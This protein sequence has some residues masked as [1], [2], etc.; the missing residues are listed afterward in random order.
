[1]LT[2]SS[3]THLKTSAIVLASTLAFV[4]TPACL[5]TE[6]ED[7]DGGGGAG[8]SGAEA[9]SG[10]D[11]SG[12]GG[13][14]S[15]G[16]GTGGGVTGSGG[17]G[18]TMVTQKT[19]GNPCSS[20]L[21]VNSYA[22]H[23]VSDTEVWLGCG[24]ATGGVYRSTDGGA[25]WQGY[26]FEAGGSE[27]FWDIET[28]S[29]GDVLL[30]G[31][32]NPSG[33]D[34][35]LLIRYLAAEDSFETVLTTADLLALG[36]TGFANCHNVAV[37]GTTIVIDDS[38]GTQLAVSE[39]D[40][41]TWSKTNV[42]Q[43][44][45]MRASSDGL[46]GVGGTTGAGPDFYE[47]P[48]SDLSNVSQTDVPDTDDNMQEGRGIG[49]TDSGTIVIAGAFD[50]PSGDDPYIGAWFRYSTDRGVTWQNANVPGAEIISFI[51]DIDC[52]GETCFA[53][54]RSFPT[55]DGLVFI[56]DDG[57]ANWSRLPL[58][59]TLSPFY[60]VDVHGNHAYIAGDG[61]DFVVLSF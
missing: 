30:C 3:M 28:D 10:G 18:V 58:D 43:I 38:T 2:S 33:S 22:V 34:D 14:G 21:G 51:E 5:L 8:G 48:L 1:M 29:H 12:V 50:T 26:T 15:G 44:W 32:V 52:V 20:Q 31:N 60:S 49:E 7:D 57:G 6:S 46:I 55:D 47:S 53:A 17:G 54:G 41:A 35:P 37:F 23:A 13:N 9:G 39:D 61:G 45:T 36:G 19:Y 59:G 24:S 16:A 42:G 56:T 27:R 40:G 4:A 11:A 25:S